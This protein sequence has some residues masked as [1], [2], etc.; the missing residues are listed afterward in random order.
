MSKTLVAFSIVLSV[1]LIMGVS[2][3]FVFAQTGKIKLVAANEEKK[4]T[5]EQA[6]AFA[7]E[8]RK[9]VLEKY[10]NDYKSKKD[11]SK[12]QIAL[13]A[14]KKLNSSKKLTK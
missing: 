11:D 8:M 5:A 1:L 14:K 13:D 4:K 6:K 2:S 7:E 10:H 3:N 9:K 12:K